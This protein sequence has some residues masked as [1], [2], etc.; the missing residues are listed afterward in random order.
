[1]FCVLSMYPRVRRRPAH[2]LTHRHTHAHTNTHTRGPTSAQAH[3][4]GDV[5]S[6]CVAYCR[7]S[8]WKIIIITL[9]KGFEPAYRALQHAI[10]EHIQRTRMRGRCG[11]G[12]GSVHLV[13][14]S[15][16]F[17]IQQVFS[18]DGFLATPR[19]DK[20]AATNRYRQGPA[21][22]RL[23]MRTVHDV[24]RCPQ[25]GTANSLVS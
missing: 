6:Y 15:E 24:T 16:S 1:M 13:F 2:A 7:P 8:Q 14:S 17:L 18:L 10:Q 19:I 5:A 23:M 21:L 20:N 11:P 4:T 25:R 12:R 3:T 9:W 22:M